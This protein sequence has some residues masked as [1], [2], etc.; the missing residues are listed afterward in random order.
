MVHDIINQIPDRILMTAFGVL[1]QAN[2]HAC[3]MDPG[4]EYWDYMSIINSAHAGELFIKA[5]V[6]Q[7][8][9]LLI[10]K[11]LCEIDDKKSDTLTIDK[12]I[13]SG[14]TYEFSKLPNLYWI[15][16]GKRIPNI[17]C[18]N[19]IKDARNSIQHFCT[20]DQIDLRSLSIEFIYTIIDPI[21]VDHFNEYAINFH[22]DHSIGYD[23]LVECIMKNK[24]RFS[25]PNN[26]DITEFNISHTFKEIEP[27][28]VDREYR[29]WFTYEMQ[30]IGNDKLYRQCVS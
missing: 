3:F 22:E 8:H 20:P 18:Y 16:T 14:Y 5:A 11:N 21:I 9:P 12:I 29:N 1:S 30:R 27:D 10:F 2:T 17:S 26:F 4:N 28:D 7:I 15:T 24:Q 19:R 23:Y 25:I 13:R 6:A